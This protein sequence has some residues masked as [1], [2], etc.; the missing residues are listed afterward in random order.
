MSVNA[1]PPVPQPGAP[2]AQPSAPGKT[3]TSGLAIAALV[4]GIVAILLS[5]IPI[6]NNLAFIIALVGII[7]GII[8]L[9]LLRKGGKGGKGLAIVGVIL[10]V[11]A[12]VIT[13][14]VQAMAVKA[15][16]DAFDEATTGPKAV[17][18]SE[19]STGE[20]GGASPAEAKPSDPL[21]VGQSIKLDNGLEVKV[22]AVNGNYTDTIGETSV[23][24]DVTYTNNGKDKVDFNSWDWKGIDAQGAEKG[25]A[26]V[27]AGDDVTR[28]DS[29]SLTAGGTVSG[30]IF[31]EAGTVQVNYY[32]NLF[33]DKAAASW[34]VS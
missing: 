23:K 3:G 29:G 17:S 31:L 8:G 2:Q 14:V 24:V 27:M 9:V 13:L 20:N 28:L 22:D 32:S 15:L 26:L 19:A 4:L 25:S 1:Q 5:F 7:L 21:N 11:L 30:S 18:T 16:N 33:S 34:K 6:I 12:I 10:S